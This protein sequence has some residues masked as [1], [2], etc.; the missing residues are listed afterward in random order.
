MNVLFHNKPRKTKIKT[1]KG[2]IT[3]YNVDAD[4][5]A[6]G[7]ADVSKWSCETTVTRKILLHEIESA[8]FLEY[9]SCFK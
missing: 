5:N 3:F 2:K 8:I 1:S 4:V 6:D 7:D 9:S